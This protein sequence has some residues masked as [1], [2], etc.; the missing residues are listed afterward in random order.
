MA[1]SEMPPEL[2]ETL[3]SVCNLFE[4]AGSSSVCLLGGSSGLLLRDVPLAVSPRDI[5]LYADLGEADSLH[6]A[7]S[8]WSIDNPE[9]DYSKGCFS[10][11]SHYSLGGYPV[12]LVCGFRVCS[13]YSQYTVE[14]SLLLKDAPF[15]YYENIGYLRLMPLAHELLFNI[16]RGRNDRYENIAAVMREDLASHVPL[17][18]TLINRNSLEQFHLSLL[19]ELLSVS[20]SPV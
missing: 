11:T 15:K 9:E 14:T 18:N 16:L 20:L 8:R 10:L 19:E 1:V 2:R 5:D 7:L 12:E 17:L 3:R 13:G 4:R 6:T